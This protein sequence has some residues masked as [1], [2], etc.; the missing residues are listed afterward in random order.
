MNLNPDLYKLF[1]SNPVRFKLQV[2]APAKQQSF[3]RLIIHDVPSNHYGVVEIPTA[4]VG[5]LPPLEAQ[6]APAKGAAEP[7]GTAPRSTG[8]Q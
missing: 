4:E 6:N 2:S 7:A 5:D 8:K 3:M 1:E